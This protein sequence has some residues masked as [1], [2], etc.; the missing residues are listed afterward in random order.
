V[1][2]EQ[3]AQFQKWVEPDWPDEPM[4]QEVHLVRLILQEETRDMTPEERLK[5]LNAQA[6]NARDA[7]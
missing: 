4:L 3:M 6:R 2:S 1:T 5:Y 7:A